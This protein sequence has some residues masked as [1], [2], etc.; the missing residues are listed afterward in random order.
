MI[1]S[2]LFRLI[3]L[4]VPK[5]LTIVC[6]SHLSN[7]SVIDEDY[8]R[9]SSCALNEISM[10]LL[11]EKKEQKDMPFTTNI[12]DQIPNLPENILSRLMKNPADIINSEKKV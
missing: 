9:T 4:I 6:L 12:H 3:G 5:H 10:L 7:L 1:L 2:I 8:S 11:L